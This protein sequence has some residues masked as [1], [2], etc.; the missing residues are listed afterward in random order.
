MKDGCDSCYN[1][2]CENDRFKVLTLNSAMPQQFVLTP[3]KVED[4][5]TSVVDFTFGPNTEAYFSC[6]GVHAGKHYVFGGSKQPRQVSIG[7]VSQIFSRFCDLA[8]H[9]MYGILTSSYSI[10]L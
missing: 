3:Y 5:S 1:E 4:E 6:G 9:I 8:L 7:T 10:W 2:I